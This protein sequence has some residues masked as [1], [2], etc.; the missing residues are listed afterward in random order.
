MG[1]LDN[2]NVGDKLLVTSRLGWHVEVVTKIHKLHVITDKGKFRKSDGKLVGA[3]DWYLTFAALTTDKEIA[4]LR[5]KN[6]LK[7]ERNDFIYQCRKIDFKTLSID[8]L[9]KIIEIVNA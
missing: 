1:K 3:D 8:K 4:E 6:R 9:K 7:R 2:A 5:E